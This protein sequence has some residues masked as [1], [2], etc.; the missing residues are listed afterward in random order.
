[1]AGALRADAVDRIEASLD[2][3]AMLV[4]D[5]DDGDVGVRARVRNSIPAP[6]R[7]AID[8][9]YSGP[10]SPVRRTVLNGPPA[11][12]FTWW[13]HAVRGTLAGLL[14]VPYVL[15]GWLGGCPGVGFRWSCLRMAVRGLVG[16]PL[17][18]ILALLAAPLDS[19]RYF[20]FDFVRRC[21]KD[22]TVSEYLDVSS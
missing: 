18:R 10:V 21:V 20:E 13:S 1:L 6:R 19:V 15:L 3:R 2:E 12:K 22:L 16:L 7:L 11:P 8:L 9:I 17:S 14:T 5:D 4:G